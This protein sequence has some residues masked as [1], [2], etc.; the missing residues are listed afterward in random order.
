MALSQVQKP[1][2]AVREEVAEMAKSPE[3]ERKRWEIESKQAE[4]GDCGGRR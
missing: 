3:V 1:F 2:A 4:G